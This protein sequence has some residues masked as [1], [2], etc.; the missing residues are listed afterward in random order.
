MINPIAKQLSIPL[1]RVYANNVLFDNEGSYLGVDHDEPT[2]RDGGK[3]HVIKRLKNAHGYETVIMIGDATVI[4]Y[5][6]LRERLRVP[7]Y[8]FFIYFDFTV[9]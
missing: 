6:A 9:F 5:A 1:H 8:S 3:T 7:N 2:C 4:G